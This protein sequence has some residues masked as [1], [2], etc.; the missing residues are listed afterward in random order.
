MIYTLTLNPAIDLELTVP[1]I[2]FNQVL[3]ATNSNMDCGGKGFNVSRALATLGEKSI[4]MGFVG[5]K[6]GERLETDLYHMGIETDFVRVVGETRTNVSIVTNPPSRYIKVNGS[7]PTVNLEKQHELIKKIRLLARPNDIWVLSGSLPPVVSN[8]IYADVIHE[9][10]S[11]GAKA[12]LDT[13]D[14]P[15]NFGIEA[16]PFMVKL[17]AEEANQLTGVEILVPGDALHAAQKIRDL[18]VEVVIISCG[19]EGAMLSWGDHTWMAKPPQVVE[20]NPVG[21]G[22]ALMAGFIWGLN[23]SL[24]PPEALRKGVTCG[25]AAASLPGTKMG[26][27]ELINFLWVQTHLTKIA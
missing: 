18:G 8:G 7:G 10:Q 12:I 26:N 13:S 11:E 27:I 19:K 24:S 21:A 2:S 20:Q 15:L 4:A 1:D 9:V 14:I 3:R 17:N 25:A 23:H 22:D 16:S 5:G 6:S